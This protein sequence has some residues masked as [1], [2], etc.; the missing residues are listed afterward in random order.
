MS[1]FLGLVIS[2][3]VSGAVY[4][5]LAGGL[6]LTYSTSRIFNFGHAAT[7]FATAYLFFQLYFGLHWPKWAALLLSAFIFAPLSGVLWDRFVFRRLVGASEAA[8]IVGSVG[9]LIV[10]PSLV[11]FVIDVLKNTFDIGF[12][13]ASVAFTVPGLGPDTPTQWKLMQ[14]VTINSD[15]VVVLVVGLVVFVALWS[16]MRFTPL[17]LRMRAS[18]D[19]PN[20]ARLR[21]TNVN[22]VST[23]AWV[24]SFFIAGIAG[25]LAA[26]L[27]GAFGLG[28][29][30]Y[31]MALF[32]AATAAMIARLS[33][34]P[35]AF[36]A[37]MGLGALRNLAE[38]YLSQRYLGSFGKWIE[39]VHGLRSST[40]FIVLFVV[41]M[42]VRLDHG[43]RVAGTVAESVVPPR[44]LE[45]M[46]PLRRNLPWII[47][48]AALLIYGLFMAGAIW[49][50]II[51]VGL[52]MGLIYLSF[53][54][55]TGIGGIVSLAQ[56][57]FAGVS[58]VT[59]GL[60]I[61]KGWP[62]LMAVA[63]GVAASTMLGILTALP[64]LRLGG[65]Q[66]TLATLAVALLTSSVVMNIAW[67]T[68]G[69]RGWK[70]PAPRLGSLNFGAPR[71]QMVVLVVLVLIAGRLVHNLQRSAAGRAM[72]AVRSSAPAAAA[73]GVSLRA[74][75]L[76]VFAVSA[77][78]AGF[79]GS[80]LAMVNGSARGTSFPPVLGFLWLA[81][82]VIFGL[83]RPQ[84]AV[85]AG[86]VFAAMPRIIN[87]GL[88]IGDFGWGG[89]TSTLI[90]PLLFGFGAVTLAKQPH[91]IAVHIHDRQ[92]ARRAKREARRAAGI[93]APDT[94]F[95][96]HA[97]VAAATTGTKP[98][99]A[100]LELVDVYAGYGDAEVLHG[101]SLR[102]ER[103][104][105]LALL[106]PNG[107]GKSTLCGVIG[108]LVPATSGA[109]LFDGV[110]ITAMPAHERAKAG[111]MLVPESRGIFPSLSVEENLRMWLPNAADRDKV[112][113]RF[114]N[115][116]VR[117]RVTAGNLSGGEQQMLS[118]APLIA[119]PPAVL[120]ADEPALGLSVAVAAAVMNAF[121]MLRDSGTTLILVEE[122]SRDV[123][124]VAD[125]VGVL[126]LGTLPWVAPA[127][128]LDHDAL[129]AAYLGGAH[130]STRSQPTTNS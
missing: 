77:A 108:G 115:L 1:T 89:T 56:A 88:H 90:A 94:G 62:F 111:V 107:A 69:S 18:V 46:S 95:D 83:Q 2:G 68:N 124:T 19:S 76:T 21:G 120:V 30:N 66:L 82:V 57:A 113:E 123:L 34:I 92:A 74:S 48:S 101:V 103:G 51:L 3:L 59:T 31:T 110:D 65:L 112:Y 129:T 33:S 96:V 118:L 20:V 85:A 81:S 87:K 53:T 17:G 127:D 122:K 5:L 104:S 100:Q 7:S 84:T 72:A 39:G 23:V 52:A 70:I 9:V 86:L 114:D 80:M 29:D 126:S 105:V 75:K 43:R 121:R 99:G 91:G 97:S 125:T 22:T 119:R 71:V 44:Y 12:A 42:V 8:R 15:Q 40:P 36:A 55:V 54:I 16:V 4:S 35:V 61:S 106:G 78:F 50:G 26:P 32:V 37:G 24:L 27:A 49:R 41:L 6:V 25:V 28:A 13:D 116:A 98:T 58:A 45:S 64:A 73:S 117:R 60:L 109:L 79:G 11:L 128:Q 10:M 67:F 63:G 93:G 47:A 14:G 38:G 130:R 102:V